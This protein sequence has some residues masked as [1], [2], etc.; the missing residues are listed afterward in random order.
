MTYTLAELAKHVGG[1]L[2]S[3]HGCIVSGV[4]TLQSAGQGD[5]SFLANS[6]YK[7]YLETSKA[8][9]IILSEQDGEHCLT[10]TIICANPYLAYA[11]IATLLHPDNTEQSGQHASAMVADDAAVDVT[12]SIGANC[13]IESGA[14][15]GARVRIE[16]GSVIGRDVKIGD[17]SRI[18]ANVTVYNGCQ[19]GQR[20][21]IHSGV[22]IGADGFGIAHSPEGWVKVPQLG[23]V[24]IGDDVEVGAN[25]TI[26]RGA[27]EDTVIGNGVKLDNQIQVAHNVKIGDHTVAAAC[28]GIAG[29][30]S[31]GS[32]CV[33]AGGVGIAGHL[34]IVD[35]VTITAMSLVTK[36]IAEAG[37]YSSGWS[38]QPQS[39]WQRQVAGLRRIPN[40]IRRLRGL[41]K[42]D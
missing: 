17:D 13:V 41:G 42:S 27:L 32:N 10:H 14:K 25:T 4:A 39:N 31:I 9:A 3:G 35:G 23:R 38:A 21:L 37:V 19:F 15:V 22:V 16:H 34:T 1:S 2:G 33:I 28:S 6:H 7:K 29:S 30:T 20:C 12:A 40:I 26:D 24:I 36:S 18:M 11:R 8:T 5:I